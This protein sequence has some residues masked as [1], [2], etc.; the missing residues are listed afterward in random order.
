[1]LR[2]LKN[3][4][5]IV[6]IIVSLLYLSGIAL[7][8]AGM[9]AKGLD[10]IKSAYLINMG[11][12]LF[13][14]IA[15]YIL[16]CCFLVDK[17]NANMGG[18]FFQYLIDVIY[19]GLFS[20]FFTGILV[21]VPSW[22]VI[23][24]LNSTVYFMVLPTVSYCFYRYISTIFKSKD[25]TDRILDLCLNAGLIV[26][27]LAVIANLFTGIYFT[28]DS[29]GAYKRGPLF[30]LIYVYI[31]S[32]I[33]ITI[34]IAFRHRSELARNQVIALS[35]FCGGPIAVA[36]IPNPTGGLSLTC[37][38]M[39]AAM[40]VTYCL[41][42]IEQSKEQKAREQELATASAIQN[43]MLPNRFPAFPER[44]EF[45]IYACM[46]PAKEVG[47]D[48]YDMF[49]VDDDHLAMVIADVSGK[50][51]T[52]ALFMAFSKQMIQF[53]TLLHNGDIVKALSV[54]N[55]RLLEE[56]VKDMFVTVWL[57]LLT[58][59]SGDLIYVNAGHEYPAIYKAGGSFVIEKDIHSVSVAAIKKAKFKINEM[60]LSPGDRL[61][62]YT[63]GVTEAKDKVGDMFGLE[64]LSDALNEVKDKPLKE[65]D[66]HVRERIASFVGDIEQYDDITTL[67]FEYY[68]ADY[69]PHHTSRQTS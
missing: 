14:M 1:M 61:Y 4:R 19:V 50:G 44:N 64:R 41:V 32:A 24:R 8:F 35:V 20:D 57:G 2:I 60:K 15:G 26:S 49:M 66:D 42:S 43:R 3:R 36:V 16:Y 47:G 9:F 10:N 52:G 65:M 30:F 54:A 11:V 13:G 48:Y 12:D 51:I 40:I 34:V 6:L 21:N 7:C 22:H 58:I 62:L 28:I 29:T 53:Q 56:S 25:K 5:F 33:T 55:K 59:S 31:F 27:L 39:M 45:D 37:G 63:D 38:I 68:G 23:Y 46:T 18:D 69:S 17:D 67:C